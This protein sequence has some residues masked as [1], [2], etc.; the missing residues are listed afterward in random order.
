[1]LINELLKIKDLF[2]DPEFI[3]QITHED[4][5]GYTN[6]NNEYDRDLTINM[7][8]QLHDNMIRGKGVKQ[9]FWLMDASALQYI[10]K[11]S[12]LITATKNIFYLMGIPVILAPVLEDSAGRIYLANAMHMS[13]NFD[14]PNFTIINNEYKP[15]GMIKDLNSLPNM[16]LD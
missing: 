1:M 4:N 3:E 11:I 12:K 2:S 5:I 6:H 15:I 13:M 10:I 9:F 8:L 7:I 14:E 16:F